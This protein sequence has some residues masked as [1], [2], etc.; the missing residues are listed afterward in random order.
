M[1]HTDHVNLIRDG[2]AD[3]K[4]SLWADFGSGE[5]AFT[6]ALAELLDGSGQIHSVDR[7]SR[8][9]E[10]QR[11]AMR[12][13]FPKQTVTYHAAD[14]TRQ[15]D[16]PPLDGVLMA[17]SLHFIRDKAPVLALMRGYLKSG[18]RLLVVEYNTDS[19][20]AWVP[21]PFSCETWVEM[22]AKHGFTG[23]HKLSARPS[24][25]LGEIYSALSIKG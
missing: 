21:Y 13:R 12:S 25:F 4:G 17:N 8:A 16:L 1:N 14:F 7:D 3:A 24:R 11:K 5:G 23:T 15:L 6:L 9:L 2:M 22:A 10:Q 19:G 20:N 18:G